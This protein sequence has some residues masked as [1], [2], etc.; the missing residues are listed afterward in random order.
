MQLHYRYLLRTEVKILSLAFFIGLNGFYSQL[1]RIM[2]NRYSEQ[3]ILRIVITWKS[4]CLGN[5]NSW[6][7]FRTFRLLLKIYFECFRKVDI[8]FH[9]ITLGK[10]NTFANVYDNSLITGSGISKPILL[11]SF[12]FYSD[13]MRPFYLYQ[14]IWSWLQN[15]RVIQS[16][17]NNREQELANI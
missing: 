17:W 14:H 15:A 8:Y 9:T 5:P 16:I 11:I 2:F 3:F 10:K 4:V 6:K 12:T 1:W 13:S 7:R